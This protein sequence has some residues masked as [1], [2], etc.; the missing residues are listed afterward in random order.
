[1]SRAQSI[2]SRMICARWRREGS[3]LKTRKSHGVWMGTETVLTAACLWM[4][5][6]GEP[7]ISYTDVLRR[8]KK[9]P[10]FF[11]ITVSLF[12]IRTRKRELFTLLE[13]GQRW[14]AVIRLRNWIH[15]CIQRIRANT[16]KHTQLWTTGYVYR[17]SAPYLRQR[18]AWFS[19][20][21]PDRSF[22]LW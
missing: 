20:K 1:V 10:S 5:E 18:W 6:L 13:N 2:L 15:V 4:S 16:H 14:T 7:R 8:R 12:L 3:P 22:N 21:S 11:S 19:V 9:T 17:G